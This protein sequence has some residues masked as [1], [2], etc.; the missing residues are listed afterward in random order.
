MDTNWLKLRKSWL[1][2]HQKLGKSR[3]KQVKSA[4][5]VPK[6]TKN[7]EKW[8]KVGLNYKTFD[9]NEQKVP[10]KSRKNI[11]KYV[12]LKKKNRIKMQIIHQ[13]SWQNVEKLVE[14]GEN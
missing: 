9:K 10:K 13:K 8:E 4:E 2:N 7:V 3:L 12:K 1:K 5:V 6:I 11:K 14:N